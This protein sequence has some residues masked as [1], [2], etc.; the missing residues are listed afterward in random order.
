MDGKKVRMPAD[1]LLGPDLR[2]R[3]ARYGRASGGF[4]L[5]SELERSL[6]SPRLWY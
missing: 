2:I 5:Y 4:M 6:R 1:F 3:S